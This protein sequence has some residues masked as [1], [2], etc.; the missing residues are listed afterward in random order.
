M[1]ERDLQL[2]LTHEH[3]DFDALASLLG[4]ALLFPEATPVLPRQ[5]NRNVRE[6]ASL[7]RSHLPFVQPGELPRARVRKV[8]LVD[9]RA[10]NAPR[11]LAP[12]CE[13]LVI[14]HHA[15]Q[16]DDEPARPR[17]QRTLP[18]SWQ[19]WSEPVGANTTLLVEKISE[20]HLSLTPVQS[21]LLVLGIHEDTG[22]LTYGGTT[23]RDARALA[24]LL[25]P[26]RGVNMDIVNRFLHHPLAPRQRALLDQLIA[27]SELLE[28]EGHNVVVA[29]AK[30]P[31]FN[32]EIS[33]VAARLR[34]F[35]EP[36]AI[37]L[38]IEL[39]DMVQVVA[40]STTSEIDVGAIARTLG[41]GGHARAAAA[42]IHNRTTT[43][44]RDEIVRLL[45]EQA[46]AAVAVRDIM[47]VGRPQSLTPEMTINE[48][49]NLM[50]RYGHEGF[51]VVA[52]LEGKPRLLGVLT[53][54]ETDRA[55]SHGLGAEKVRRFMR[56]G[57]TTVHPDDSIPLL[58]RRMIDSGWGQI[59]VVDDH[60]RIIGIVTRTD[61]IKL[62]DDSERPERPADEVAR[63]LA[64]RLSPT[65]HALLHMIGLEVD[66][67][68]YT[69]YVVGGFVR[70]LLLEN[71]L[72]QAALFDLDIVI[73]GDATVFAN[74]LASLYG[75]RVVQ[76]RQFGTAKWLLRDPSAPAHIDRLV[77][78]LGTA[79]HP[80]DLP[81]H[82]DFVSAR[83]E[84]Y[85]APSVLPTVES[86]SIKLDLHRRDFSINTLALCLN[87]RRWGQLLDFYGGLEDL[88][89]G[90]VR[91]LHSLSFVD[92]PTRILR[93]V[94]YE[95]R[96][97]FHIDSRTLELMA[98]ALDLLDRVT[99]ARVRHELERFLEEEAPESIFIRLD[100][101]GILSRIHPKLRAGPWLQ[102]HFARL[103]EAYA[104]A[105]TD[106][107]L[108]AEPLPRLYW[109][110]L[111]YALPVDADDALSERL[112][113]RRE[114]QQLVADVHFVRD[115]LSRLQDP[116]LRPSEAVLILDE[117]NLPALA[118]VDLIED[119]AAFHHVRRQYVDVWR[120]V[121]TELN[122]DDLRRLGISPGLVYREILGALRAARLD[123][124]ATSRADELAIA[125]PYVRAARE[126]AAARTR[127]APPGPSSDPA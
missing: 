26:E 123:G 11:G 104:A 113:L 15:P 115:H 116:N 105:P 34:D 112:A 76:H 65:R 35:H 68:N 49:A 53:R 101:L 74:R 23:H 64:A 99:P 127:S 1:G 17:G 69:V 87:P 9:T 71:P 114:T 67:L 39:G 59:P 62:W 48:A 45:Q 38:I 119:D 41:G 58:R 81:A 43:D 5:M 124:M 63:R 27:N 117:V 75:G 57:T 10:L 92:D 51:P 122:G 52:L 94:R 56:A 106:D 109:A 80:D 44:I 90:V 2:I 83:T 108:R 86:S 73:E 102:V 3:T 13:V 97:H 24:W 46:R 36:D 91:V 70:D 95:Q 37:F 25:E 107:D 120:H 4:A 126:A 31:D 118:L 30:A 100:D 82:L 121:R 8:L 98:D 85:T 89:K 77:A 33:T 12:E 84:F 79:A 29:Q 110:T 19:V 54:R 103:R 16:D 28:L 55:I 7:Y 61:L 78:S 40:R 47:S 60:G 20:A 125:E 96:F 14:D 32:E 111:V 66:A 93:A 18:A 72:P 88:R 6:F 50:R 21:T 42:P 22:S